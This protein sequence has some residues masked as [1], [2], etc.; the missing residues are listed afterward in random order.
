MDHWRNPWQTQQSPVYLRWTKARLWQTKS[1]A[2]PE[3]SLMLL[4]C[5]LKIVTVYINMYANIYWRACMHARVHLHL[6]FSS[7]SWQI[8]AFHDVP[9]QRAP[10]LAEER[11]REE[12]R[13][14]PVFPHQISQQLEKFEC[15][16]SLLRVLYW[17]RNATVNLCFQGVGYFFILKSSKFERESELWGEGRAVTLQN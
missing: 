7:E 8:L 5:F 9:R 6:Q 13:G 17:G 3:I 11:T 14:T 1:A 2:V 12:K 15:L 10:R 4:L 16:F